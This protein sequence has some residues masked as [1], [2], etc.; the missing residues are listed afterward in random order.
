MTSVGLLIIIL[1]WTVQF[2]HTFQG[3]HKLS[4]AFVF[5]YCLGVL[6]LVLDG[7]LLGA[8]KIANLNLLSLI[9]SVSVFLCLLGTKSQNPLSSAS[10]ETKHSRKRK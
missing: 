9:L 5:C 4:K 7:Y 1:A 8:Q 3:D 6:I 10:K 2:V